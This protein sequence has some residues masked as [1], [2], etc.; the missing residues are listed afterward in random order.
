MTPK[1][2]D[3]PKIED[4]VNWLKSNLHRLSQF[5]PV[6][7][8]E[9]L[10][11]EQKQL[12]HIEH[13]LLPAMRIVEIFLSEVGVDERA[14]EP[15]SYV[16]GAFERAAQGR[17]HELFKIK[18][19]RRKQPDAEELWLSRIPI[20]CLGSALKVEKNNTLF[21]SLCD[22]LQSDIIALKS[23]GGRRGMGS[24]PTRAVNSWIETLEG[25]RIRRG[26]QTWEQMRPL[27]QLYFLKRD[28]HLAEYSKL[29]GPARLRWFEKTVAAIRD[30]LNWDVDE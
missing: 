8:T 5:A 13:A 26:Q 1:I 29:S 16:V 20:A 9:T 11:G 25:N 28:R 7:G 15:I 24:S 23:K 18:I 3:W 2:I 30:D 21:R 17:S 22:Q 19:G 6:E 4:P 14:R 10:R 12:S 27:R